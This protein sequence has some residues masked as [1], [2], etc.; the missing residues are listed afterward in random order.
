VPISDS[1]PW[2]FAD[3]ERAGRSFRDLWSQSRD[4]D[5]AACGIGIPRGE[6][7][8]RVPGAVD[9]LPRREDRVA[10]ARQ[11]ALEVAG[12]ADPGQAGVDDR[13]VKLH[14]H[15]RIE[16]ATTNSS[17]EPAAIAFECRACTTLSE[18]GSR[19]GAII[20]VSQSRN[21]LPVK[22]VHAQPQL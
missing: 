11:A 13:D 17:P 14:G 8:E 12:G 10:L 21:L 19:N 18:R 1:P 2:D 7:A 4:F 15:W 22:P 6:V 5:L 16:S 3:I 20:S 9:R